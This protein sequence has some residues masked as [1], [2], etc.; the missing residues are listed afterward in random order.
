MFP[1]KKSRSDWGKSGRPLPAIT[2]DII[3]PRQL[4]GTGG[5]RGL[6]GLQAKKYQDPQPGGKGSFN[7]GLWQWDR[8]GRCFA[9]CP[10]FTNNTTFFS[11]LNTEQRTV[12]CTDIDDFRKTIKTQFSSKYYFYKWNPPVLR[13]QRHTLVCLA[14]LGRWWWWGA[15]WP[16]TFFPRTGTVWQ[17]GRPSTTS[18]MPPCLVFLPSIPPT[19]RSSGPAYW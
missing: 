6:G 4:A 17:P 1:G 7:W 14:E 11:L 5:G 18:S 2:G 8:V 19:V 12:L 15:L 16:F 3:N 10:Y 13:F 9:E